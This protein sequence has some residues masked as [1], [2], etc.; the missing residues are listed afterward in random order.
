MIK[1]ERLKIGKEIYEHKINRFQA[2][3]KYHISNWTARN[4]VRE[5]KAEL[6]LNK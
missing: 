4:Y 1:Q 5:Y 2:A 6:K 3:E